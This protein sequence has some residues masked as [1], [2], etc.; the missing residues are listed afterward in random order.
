[1]RI[2]SKEVNYISL[3]LYRNRPTP[4]GARKERSYQAAKRRVLLGGNL[5]IFHMKAAHCSIK[6]GDFVNLQLLIVV[7]NLYSVFKVPRYSAEYPK[8]QICR[9]VTEKLQFPASHVA[10]FVDNAATVRSYT[11]ELLAAF[12]LV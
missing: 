1:M 2:R 9:I 6:Y 5:S 7:A 10:V 12:L 3:K 11:Y 8:Y 4:P